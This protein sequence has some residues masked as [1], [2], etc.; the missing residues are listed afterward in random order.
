MCNKLK[1]NF[2]NCIFL[3]AVHNYVSLYV[4]KLNY[5]KIKDK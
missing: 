5:M 4:Q 2:Y 3:E 1:Y